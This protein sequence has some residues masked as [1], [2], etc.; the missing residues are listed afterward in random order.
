[1][2][3]ST[4]RIMVV[5]N[6]YCIRPICAG[7]RKDFSVCKTYFTCVGPL[8]ILQVSITSCNTR[9][10]LQLPRRTL[11][12]RHKMYILSFTQINTIYICVS[13]NLFHA[14]SFCLE[15]WLFADNYVN[16]RQPRHLLGTQM[17][18]DGGIQGA[19][20]HGIITGLQSEPAGHLVFWNIWNSSANKSSKFV[21][22]ITD[23]A[24]DDLFKQILSNPNHVLVPLP[25]LCR[26]GGLV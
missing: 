17:P 22:D 2:Y 14:D 7:R 12:I 10:L 5:Q 13:K 25:P 4:P 16:S 1:M 15:H 21:S 18:I 26:V 8:R 9:C 19:T 6:T 24:D 20:K 3:Q 23:R 11:A